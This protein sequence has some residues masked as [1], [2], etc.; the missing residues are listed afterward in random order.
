MF[1]VT[2]SSLVAHNERLFA[3]STFRIC[4]WGTETN[5]Y[6]Y[7]IKRYP[8]MLDFSMERSKK[9][10]GTKIVQNG[11][12]E[13]ARKVVLLPTSWRERAAPQQL[14]QVPLRSACTVLAPRNKL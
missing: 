9:K 3:V 1:L 14:E 8:F 5:S 7:D 4:F 11:T 2:F 12:R 10:F 13:Y 6:P